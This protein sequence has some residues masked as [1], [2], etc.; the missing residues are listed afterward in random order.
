MTSET[1]L[2][3]WKRFEAIPEDPIPW[4]L[5]T[6]RNLLRHSERGRSRRRALEHRLAAEPM[7]SEGDPPD[8]GERAEAFAAAFTGLRERDREALT[9]ISWDDLDPAEA[10]LSLGISVAAFRVRLHRA[11]RRLKAALDDQRDSATTGG[12]R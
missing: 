2:I 5:S 3:A 6:A 11:R 10:A 8:P 12:E 9:L 1:F 4:L 7:G